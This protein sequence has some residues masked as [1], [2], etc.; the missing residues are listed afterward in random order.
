MRVVLAALVRRLLGRAA[1]VVDMPGWG[2]PAF[3]AAGKLG[4][5]GTVVGIGIVVVPGDIQY[6]RLGE[7][8]CKTMIVAVV[9]FGVVLGE[10]AK[11]SEQVG[12]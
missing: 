12:L 1:S 11:W 4:S 5:A 9:P 3:G 8:V 7:T 2:R 6:M 10:V